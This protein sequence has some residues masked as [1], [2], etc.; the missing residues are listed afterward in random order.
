MHY[1]KQRGRLK[2]FDAHTAASAL[3]LLDGRFNSKAVQVRH[4]DLGDLFHLLRT[5]SA[6]LVLIWFGRAFGQV[7]RS[8]HEN[9]NGWSFGDE[10]EG[11]IRIDRD[12]HGDNEALLIL[13]GGFRIEGLAEFHDVHA[14]RTEGGT[15][16]G[17][18]RRFASRNLQFNFSC[19]FFCHF[20]SLANLDRL[21][22]KRGLNLLYL[23]EVEFHGSRSSKNRDQNSK[24]IAFEIDL[25][26]L[27]REVREWSVDDLH[28][29]ILL[30]RHLWPWALGAG[31]LPIENGVYFIGRQRN[32]FRSATNEAGDAG[33]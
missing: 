7:N 30:K 16:R 8:L 28:G 25:I 26:H 29:F 23:Q 33:R 22:Q 10:R 2:N 20:R 12:H 1:G 4:L 14:L 5:D 9:G 27:A 3:D 13:R 21:P 17:C 18:G 31:G 15:D 6:D 19:Y 11:A 24:R 32:G